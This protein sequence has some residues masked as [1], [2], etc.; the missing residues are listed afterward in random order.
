[1]I[2]ASDRV[3][4]AVSG[5]V[6]SMVLLHLMQQ[7][8]VQLGV[9][10][11]NYHLRGADSDQDQKLVEE[12]C[13]EHRIPLHLREVDQAEY[14]VGE[15]IQMIARTIRYAFFEE[16]MQEHLYSKTATAHNLNDNL[17][18]VLL[19][20]TK[21]TGIHGL[22]GIAPVKDQHIIRPLLFAS[23]EEIYAYAKQ[24]GLS[25]REDTSNQKNDYQRNRIRN[26]VI[27]ELKQINPNLE[28]TF[29]TTNLRMKGVA[30]LVDQQVQDILKDLEESNGVHQLSSI[31]VSND[32][33]SRM[34]LSEV[35][36][37][38]NVSFAMAME[39]HQAIIDASVGALFETDEWTINVDR[40]SLLIQSK[41]SKHFFQ[42]EMSQESGRVEAPGGY[43]VWTKVQGNQLPKQVSPNQAYVDFDLVEW[44]IKLRQWEQGDFFYPFGMRGKKKVS[45]FMIDSKIPVTLKEQVIVM[46]SGKKIMWLVGWRTDDRFKVT[47]GTTSMLKIEFTN[48]A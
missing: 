23:K 9:A 27:P 15:S 46:E 37:A 32:A 11:V 38:Y 1:M 25:W 18:T 42:E 20:L 13:Q 34:I 45:D 19:N 2:G 39:V 24:E 17:E 10:H 3:L 12:Y 43:L 31:W 30:E 35:L 26:R 22:T 29:A 5:G 28:A 4:V 21:G 14:A 41:G 44:P 16:L 6:D 48:H 33:K 8:E 40:E 47:S 7:A 36:K